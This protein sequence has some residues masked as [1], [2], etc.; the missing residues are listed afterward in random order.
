M[1]S[2]KEKLVRTKNITSMSNTILMDNGSAKTK[3]FLQRSRKLQGSS[4]QKLEFSRAKMVK[5]S[6]KKQKLKI[7]GKNIL[8][9][10]INV[11]GI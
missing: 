11:M 9:D 4:S 8:K 3:D 10:Y 2:F 1:L 7:D 6:L 5:I